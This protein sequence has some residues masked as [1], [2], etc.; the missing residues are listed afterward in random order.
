MWP[1][2]S[3]R[4]RM[5]LCDWTASERIPD[6]FDLPRRFGFGRT[7]EICVM[8]RRTV[9][10]H[11]GHVGEHRSQNDRKR[12]HRPKR[13]HQ[14]DKFKKDKY[15]SGK[16]GL[17][18]EHANAVFILNSPMIGMFRGIPSPTSLKPQG[19]QRT[20][21]TR[22]R[23]HLTD[24]PDITL[25]PLMSSPLFLQP[26]LVLTVDGFKR[27]WPLNPITHRRIITNGHNGFH[28]FST[29]STVS[30]GSKTA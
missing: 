13:F 8:S 7:P 21:R 28:P 25:A 15:V 16:T 19:P 17:A 30:S 26:Q 3:S 14:L 20:A 6:N 27:S 5:W 23:F 12:D 22:P 11:V 1:R 18:K 10:I 24:A 9:Y 2:D 29:G 4:I